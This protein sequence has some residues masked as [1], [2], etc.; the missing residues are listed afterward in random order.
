MERKGTESQ[1][2]D[3]NSDNNNKQDQTPTPPTRASARERKPIRTIGELWIAEQQQLVQLGSG[4]KK[5]AVAY[6]PTP[7]RSS[8]RGSAQALTKAVKKKTKP[9]I[10][11][12]TTTAPSFKGNSNISRVKGITWKKHGKVFTVRVRTGAK[13]RKYIGQF[14]TFEGE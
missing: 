2:V 13:T 14:K 10:K 11:K 6:E 12:K 9:T 4:G 1:T 5:S 8:S 7:E 3:A